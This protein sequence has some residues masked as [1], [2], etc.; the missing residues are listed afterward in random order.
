MSR[1]LA[2][3][4]DATT[5]ST[6]SCWF[7]SSSTGRTIASDDGVGLS[8]AGPARCDMSRAQPPSGNGEW[9]DDARDWVTVMVSA[10]TVCDVGRSANVRRWP[11]NATSIPL[12]RSS[13]S[14]ALPELEDADSIA[15]NR[16]RHAV[17]PHE[18]D[19]Q[20]RPG[21]LDIEPHRDQRRPSPSAAGPDGE[22]RAVLERRVVDVGDAL[23]VVDS[24]MRS[25]MR[26]ARPAPPTLSGG[27]RARR[28]LPRVR[29]AA[30]RR[31]TNSA[32]RR[33]SQ[34]VRAALDSHAS[35]RPRERNARLIAR[36]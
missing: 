2:T 36:C 23:A 10:R 28:E 31:R 29:S 19:E 4:I 14:E 9:P 11:M 1:C 15:Q 5:S 17:H 13:S 30:R 35:Q 24:S 27:S 22:A 18:A 21:R 20:S 7:G 12:S 26:A 32:S 8:T 16:Q 3:P 25:S 33:A 34:A 6:R